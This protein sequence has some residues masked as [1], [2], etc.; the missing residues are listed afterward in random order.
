MAAPRN[1]YLQALFRACPA[2]ATA[3]QIAIW[4]GDAPD[5]AL[6]IVEQLWREQMAARLPNPRGRGVVW[7]TALR[8]DAHAGFLFELDGEPMRMIAGTPSRAVSQPRRIR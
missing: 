1:I 7:R 4:V 8:A 2:G 3:A 6:R 5:E